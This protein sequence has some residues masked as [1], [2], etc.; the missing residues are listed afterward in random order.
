MPTPS[1]SAPG[2]AP[3]SAPMATPGTDQHRPHLLTAGTATFTLG[4][5]GHQ[6][7]L[8][9]AAR[10]GRIHADACPHRGRDLPLVLLR[11]PGRALHLR[12][13]D[14]HAVPEHRPH[15]AAC[16]SCA[17]PACNVPAPGYRRRP[18]RQ[19]I[20]CRTGR[21]T[22][23]RSTRPSRRRHGELHGYGNRRRRSA[24]ARVLWNFAAGS[25]VPSST[26]E[27]PGPIQFNTPGTFTV[28]FTVTD[29]LARAIRR[30]RAG[31]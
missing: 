10:R 27:D 23:R 12:R 5:G 6:R 28:T 13:L 31:W 20:S 30:P 19:T 24:S 11:H 8:Y 3:I 15:A 26:A 1:P 17:L 29:G 2:T 4:D 25:G 16:N 22:T 18:R 7:A 21:S 14:P 9:R